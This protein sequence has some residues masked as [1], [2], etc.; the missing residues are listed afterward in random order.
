MPDDGTMPMVERD[1]FEAATVFR[2]SWPDLLVSPESAE[3]GMDGCVAD[4]LG[5]F[6]STGTEFLGCWRHGVLVGFLVAEPHGRIPDARSIRF[7]AVRR[8][9]RARGVGSELVGDL[10]RRTGVPLWVRTWSGNGAALR[11]YRK[12]GFREDS[13]ILDH[14]GP[15]VDSILLVRQ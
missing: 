12:H 3:L 7:L 14:R 6:G 4:L 13:R 9:F 2:E 11:L 1:L 15:G 5:R 8:G 10:A